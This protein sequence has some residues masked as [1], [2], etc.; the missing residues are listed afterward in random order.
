MYPSAFNSQE[1]L[2]NLQLITQMPGDKASEAFINGGSEKKLQ[3]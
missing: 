2:P 3:K 1:N